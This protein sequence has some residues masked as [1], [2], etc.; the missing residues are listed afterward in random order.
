MDILLSISQK[1]DEGPEIQRSF[2][3]LA[4]DIQPME[5]SRLVALTTCVLPTVLLL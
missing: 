1:R 3:L 5:D 4:Q 2:K